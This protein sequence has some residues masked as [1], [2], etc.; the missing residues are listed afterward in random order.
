MRSVKM[1]PGRGGLAQVLLLGGAAAYAASQSICNVE[2]GHR[3]TVF[4]RLT[5]IKDEVGVAGLSL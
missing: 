2:G 3:A 4:N 1:P 5:G